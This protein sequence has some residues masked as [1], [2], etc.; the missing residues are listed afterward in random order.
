MVFGAAIEYMWPNLTAGQARYTPELS[1]T[2][3]QRAI[4]SDPLL[5]SLLVEANKSDLKDLKLKR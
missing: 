3:F 1:R 5:K 2:N 4:S